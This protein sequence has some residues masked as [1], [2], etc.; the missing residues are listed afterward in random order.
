MVRWPVVPLLFAFLA[1][2]LSLGC[3][4]LGFGGD[5]VED[6]PMGLNEFG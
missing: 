2:S 1:L 3:G 5:S 4:M 6:G